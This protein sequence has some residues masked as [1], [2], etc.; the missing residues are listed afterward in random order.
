MGHCE[1]A[2]EDALTNINIRVKSMIDVFV[3]QR[4]KRV[5]SN[6]E[7]RLIIDIL[8]DRPNGRFLKQSHAVQQRDV[9][10][11]LICPKE[12]I[13][14][15]KLESVPTFKQVLFRKVVGKPTKGKNGRYNVKLIKVRKGC[16]K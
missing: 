8:A 5:P 9:I 3:L 10:G 13:S 7:L 6:R 12:C 14:W 11:N 1:I 4:T 16:H 2:V 15:E